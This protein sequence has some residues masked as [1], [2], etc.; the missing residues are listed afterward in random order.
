M[1]VAEHKRVSSTELQGLTAPAA[2]DKSAAEVEAAKHPLVADQPKKIPKSFEERQQDIQKKD[3]L[4]SVATGG[5]SIGTVLALGG[6]GLHW[7]ASNAIQAGVVVSAA[8]QA[9]GP[10]LMATGAFCCLSGVTALFC[11]RRYL[12]E[13]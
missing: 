5:T 6:G 11:A 12:P 1:R 13:D 9:A 7:N 3:K 4:E 8:G 10:V 2:D